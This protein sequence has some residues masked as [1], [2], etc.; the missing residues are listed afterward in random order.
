MA[1]KKS[2]LSVIR[3][4][5]ASG[6]A[7]TKAVEGYTA[8]SNVSRAVSTGSSYVA[9]TPTYYSPGSSKDAAKAVAQAQAAVKAAKAVVSEYGKSTKN[10]KSVSGKYAKATEK[11]K[12]KR[13]KTKV[14]VER[15]TREVKAKYDA[16]PK[17][18]TKTPKFGPGNAYTVWE[19]SNK[20][21]SKAR[22]LAGGSK[23]L[24][25]TGSRQIA[26]TRPSGPKPRKVAKRLQKA[27]AK[28]TGG[29]PDYVPDQYRGLISKASRKS[30]VPAP[31]LS[32]LLRQ[33]SGFQA[34]IGSPAGAQ[35]IA[36]FMPATAASRGVDPNNPKSAIPGAADLLRENK[37]QFGTWGKALAAYN[38]GGGAV[39]E[40]GGIPPYPET[41]N[42]VKT[43]KAAVKEEGSGNAKAVPK[44]L[45]RTARQT[46]G[47]QPTK[48]ILQGGKVIKDKNAGEEESGAPPYKET[49]Q[50]IVPT[51]A[52]S[53]ISAEQRAPARTMVT[54]MDPALQSALVQLAKNTGIPVRINEGYR[55]EARAN[56]FPSGTASQH[57]QGNAADIDNN[58]DYSAED[59][60]KVGLNNT[61][62]GGEPWHFQLNNPDATASTV[63]T[64][65][66]IKGTNLAV[67]VPTP[68]TTGSSV[69]GV[70]G[71]AASSTGAPLS[72][73]EAAAQ[74]AEMRRRRS[75]SV[76]KRL[77]AIDRWMT[78]P[79]TA[80]T[81]EISQELIDRI[82][83]K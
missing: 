20:I 24:K 40:Y 71:T 50:Y 82:L 52:R 14:R 28:S 70:G 56:D 72:P 1:K 63:D 76:S 77:A 80:P 16:T 83:G 29:V 67:K 31:L 8:A 10:P 75:P 57:H 54:G 44:P 62:V 65:I 73:A 26:P 4:V 17:K 61:A 21:A 37:D 33:E 2:L 47:K 15:K 48:A 43:I 53:E 23:P 35:G 9:P 64:N 38:A 30:N 7:A 66:P 74:A 55:T 11:A 5:T 18:L 78:S 3:G 60:A 13:E 79:V 49:K 34:Q 68:T 42:Y 41:Q 51:E 39:S 81:P 69:S 27:V 36:Q 46:L 25:A 19:G 45:K 6:H 59:L 22:E 32:A 12:K 58:A